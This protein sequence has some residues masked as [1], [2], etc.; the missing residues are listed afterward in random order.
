MNGFCKYGDNCAFAHGEVELK[1][2]KLNSN[3]KTK[4]CKQ[5]F[6]IG[7]CPYGT[8][9]QFSHK[10]ESKIEKNEKN[11]NNV[12]YVKILYDIINGEKISEKLLK[13]PRLNTFENITK[14]SNLFEIENYRKKLFDDI[15]DLK[16]FNYSEEDNSTTFSGEEMRKRFLS[17]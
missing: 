3:Y 11:I 5:F 7:F 17:Y 15:N 9:C 10:K 1:N 13:R 4:P 8:R 2:K 6:E 14:C 16:N 12:S